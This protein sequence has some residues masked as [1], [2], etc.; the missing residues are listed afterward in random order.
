MF[1]KVADV[2]TFNLEK[3]VYLVVIPEKILQKIVLIWGL[4]RC[5]CKYFSQ[6]DDPAGRMLGE[7]TSMLFTDIMEANVACE[8]KSP[9]D[10]KSF[11]GQT[12]NQILPEGDRKGWRRRPAKYSNSK[13]TLHNVNKW[14]GFI[15]Y[16]TIE[17]Y[18]SEGSKEEVVVI[19]VLN[20]KLNI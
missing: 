3:I 15:D 19:R 16:S 9:I 2:C 4:L 1:L 7:V 13:S 14:F 20:A 12:R 6:D 17:I 10:L 5:L 8:G 11:C 18:P